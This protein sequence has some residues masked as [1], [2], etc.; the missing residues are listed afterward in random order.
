MAYASIIG[1]PIWSLYMSLALVA[2]LLFI[3]TTPFANLE[4]PFSPGGAGPSSTDCNNQPLVA[5]TKRPWH[6]L[7][8]YGT[9]RQWDSLE[10][11]GVHYQLEC[12]ISRLDEAL[13]EEVILLVHPS[14]IGDDGAERRPI[15]GKGGRPTSKSSR[16]HSSH[17]SLAP[18]QHKKAIPNTWE[19]LL[20]GSSCV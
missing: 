6:P 13:A 1:Y 12:D 20:G 5:W 19:S 16:H 7:G 14:M 18:D 11:P 3:H 10:Q 17:L 15:G 4:N 2:M 9:K 8:K